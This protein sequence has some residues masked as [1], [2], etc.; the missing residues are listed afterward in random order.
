MTHRSPPIPQI[1][2]Q[3]YSRREM[4]RFMGMTAAS[5]GLSGAIGGQALAQEAG[6]VDAM[7]ADAPNPSHGISTF[8]DLKYGPDFKHLDYVNPQAPKGGEIG[9]WLPGGFDTFNPFTVAG[10]AAALATLPLETLLAGTSDEIGASYCLLAERLDYPPS[11]DWVIFTLRAEA[12]FSDGSP[13]TAQDVVFSYDQLRLKGLSSFQVVIA[14]QVAS[15][16]A[17]DARRVKFTF[18]DGYPRRDLIQTVGGIPIFS[19]ADFETRGIDLEKPIDAPFLGSGPYIL[20]RA[21][22]GRKLVWRRND[23]Y[24]GADLPLNIG[25][26]NFDRISLTYFADYQTAFE[27]F[28]AGNYTFRSEA[29]SSIWANSY[30]FPAVQKG[31]VVK[32]QL[33]RGGIPSGQC[34]V[35]NLRRPQFADIRTREALGMLFNFEWTNETLFYGLYARVTSF[36]DLSPMAA[37]GVPTSE[38]RALLEPVAADL[39]EGILEAEAV[40]PYVAGA[41]QMD[42]KTLRAAG[43]LL[44][45]AGWIVGDDGM[46]RNANGEVL[47]VEI[48]NDSQTFDKVLNPY[49]ENMRAVGIDARN[50]RVDDVQYESRRRS[51]DFDLLTSHLGQDAITGSDLEQYF[52]SGAI[53]DVFNAMGVANPAIDALIE[54]V[55]QAETRAQMELAAR[56]LDRALRSLH[57]WVPQ[58]YAP[59]HNVAYYDMFEH[60]ETLP[61]YALG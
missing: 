12:K 29:S 24:W 44:T 6:S 13:V 20:E 47:R 19:Q 25:R 60:P 46:R 22:D 10:R 5:V 45:Q 58:W 21:T 28:K 16:E 41:R 7:P 1:I 53:D 4:L 59:T 39:P 9:E 18:V 52:G 56:V 27:G 17:L 11:R 30:D 36:W 38:E 8:G 43:E 40:E 48:L 34:F 31:H 51:F 54:N 55:V 14:K 3:G 2:A 49:V 33:P 50:S 23:A 32:R 35:I 42:R 26:N 15:A 57:F 37:K 61:P